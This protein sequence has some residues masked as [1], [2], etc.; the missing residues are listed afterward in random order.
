MKIKE[1]LTFLAPLAV[2]ITLI[3]FGLISVS[4]ES[5]KA[6]E[7]DEFQNTL[8]TVQ[9]KIAAVEYEGL[10]K[11][12]NRWLE[13]AKDTKNHD[14]RWKSLYNIGRT[15][16]E[17]LEKTSDENS[18]RVSRRNFREALRE[19]PNAFEIKYNLTYLENLAQK[20]GIE[21][22]EIP[23]ASNEAPI[24]D[25]GLSIPSGIIDDEDT[26]KNK[27]IDLKDKIKTGRAPALG[28]EPPLDITIEINPEDIPQSPKRDY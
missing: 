23:T 18:Y 5:S 11:Y 15:N 17:L 6:R 12:T 25:S 16:L 13:T 10:S 3:I 22:E 20:K 1:M 2:G 8:S 4:N 21:V 28:G 27:K 7:A 24:N 26:D 9:R 14:L 19:N